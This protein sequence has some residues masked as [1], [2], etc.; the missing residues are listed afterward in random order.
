MSV[1]AQPDRRAI[2]RRARYF[3]TS[4]YRGRDEVKRFTRELGKRGRYAVVGGM[5]R[6]LYL[7]G[8]RAF[9]SDVDFVVDVDDLPEFDRWMNVLGGVPNKFGGFGLRGSRWN[10]DVWPLKRTWAAMENHVD[11]RTIDDILRTTFFDW[12]A[13]LYAPAEGKVT[14][15]PG[16]F[17]RIGRTLDINLHPNPNP[18]GNAVR[19][20]RYAGRWGASLQPSLADHVLRHLA[21]SGWNTM[22]EVE[23]RSFG[24]CFLRFMDP[25]RLVARLQEARHGQA[26][27]LPEVRVGTIASGTPR[28]QA[29][30]VEGVRGRRMAKCEML[31]HRTAN[32]AKGDA[33]EDQAVLEGLAGG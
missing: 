2:E 10:L 25:D 9:H 22:L 31:L 20:L 29:W 17:E 5:L 7:G 28:R 21:L 15:A 8:N 26:V 11:V 32:C 23:A 13:V 27:A 3:F 33:R 16:F 12:D 19:A 24:S 30:P 18:V 4:D 6:D 14:A 1:P